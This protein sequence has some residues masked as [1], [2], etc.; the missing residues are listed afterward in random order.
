MARAVSAK[1]LLLLTLE[2][3]GLDVVDEAGEEGVHVARTARVGGSRGP[4]LAA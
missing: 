2:L 4:A 3:D 1:V